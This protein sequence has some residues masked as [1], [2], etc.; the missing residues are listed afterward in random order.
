ME[1]VPGIDVKCVCTEV[2]KIVKDAADTIP[3]VDVADEVVGDKG[4]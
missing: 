1:V 3:N 4:T 2:G